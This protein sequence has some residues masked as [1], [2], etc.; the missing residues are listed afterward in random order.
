MSYDDFVDWFL[1][2]EREMQ[3]FPLL[4]P[5]LL[6]SVLPNAPKRSGISLATDPS[7]DPKYI[8]KFGYFKGVSGTRV[9]RVEWSKRPVSQDDPYDVDLVIMI[10]ATPSPDTASDAVAHLL[11]T[12]AMLRGESL[13]IPAGMAADQINGPTRP[14]GSTRSDVTP[15]VIT[16]GA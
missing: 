12:D 16:T 9:A 15:V 6:V 13:E 3:P 14:T 8:D 5:E 10:T 1:F 2:G 11:R 7:Y 4:D